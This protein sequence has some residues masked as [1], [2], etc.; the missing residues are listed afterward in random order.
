MADEGIAD[1]ARR[2]IEGVIGNKPQVSSKKQLDYLSFYL[3]RSFYLQVKQT[4]TT[5]MFRNLLV[6]AT[7]L[8]PLT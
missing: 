8:S 5:L 2:A 7:P 1:T 4:I 6:I 3:C